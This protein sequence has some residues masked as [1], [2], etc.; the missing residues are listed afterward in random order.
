VNPRG[1]VATG[2]LA[3]TGIETESPGS[4]VETGIE[5]TPAGHSNSRHPRHLPRRDRN[6]SRLLAIAEITLEE[7]AAG[8]RMEMSMA[9][10][11]AGAIM[12]EAAAAEEIITEVTE[13]GEPPEEAA[14]LWTEVQTEEL[15]NGRK[16]AEI[17][18]IGAPEGRRSRLL[19][20]PL[21]GIGT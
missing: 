19:E 20:V 11:E 15:A 13:A 6:L 21:V 1:D 5:T 18:E 17:T 7:T 12:R 9:V 16:R 2:T 4:L 14:L 10:V 3:E 8:S